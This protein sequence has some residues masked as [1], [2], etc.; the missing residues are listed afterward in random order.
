MGKRS[1]SVAKRREAPGT[2]GN[3]ASRGVGAGQAVPAPSDIL[4]Q[5]QEAGEA[6]RRDQAAL[7]AV[8][9]RAR[10]KGTSWERIGGAIGMT[11]E[12][13]RKRYSEG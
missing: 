9:R 1:R 13:A 3:P 12:G 8:V 10:K 5:L 11:G 2:A 4:T 6:V 7:A